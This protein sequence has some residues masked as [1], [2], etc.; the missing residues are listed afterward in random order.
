[1]AA[2]RFRF[3]EGPVLRP[4]ELDGAIIATRRWPRGQRTRAGDRLEEIDGQGA[5]VSAANVVPDGGK[6]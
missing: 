1:M 6:S 2:R 4:T 5:P 3:R